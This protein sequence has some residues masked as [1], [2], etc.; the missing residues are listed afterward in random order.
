MGQCQ[1]QGLQWLQQAPVSWGK[2]QGWLRPEKSWKGNKNLSSLSKSWNHHM[3]GRGTCLLFTGVE[4]RREWALGKKQ[5]RTPPPGRSRRK[6]WGGKHLAGW[7]LTPHQLWTES[8]LYKGWLEASLRFCLQSARMEENL[9]PYRVPH[10]RAASEVPGNLLENAEFQ[11]PCQ[12]FWIR[13]C[14]LMKSPGDLCAQ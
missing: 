5:G 14:I 13:S 3:K 9:A 7:A 6:R 11:A 8:A 10:G 4:A 12:I 2:Q 1:D